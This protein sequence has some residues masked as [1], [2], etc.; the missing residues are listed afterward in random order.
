MG[1]WLNND[2]LELKYGIDKTKADLVGEFR[3]DGPV[4]CLEIDLVAV[5]MPAVASN[6][7]VIEDTNSLPKGAVIERI[8]IVKYTTFVGSGATLNIG[9]IDT[10]R[11]SNASANALVDAATI[12]E[13]NA[14][15]TNVAGWVGAGVN[16]AALTA[17]KLITWEVDTAAITQGDGELRIYYSV[18]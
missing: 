17:P 8:E 6:S 3:Y 1:T 11:S 12:A 14:G 4:R 5:R 15:G 13:L 7:V 18:P 16:A 10:D 9:L 2:G